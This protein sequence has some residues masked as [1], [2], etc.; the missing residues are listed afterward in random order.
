MPK[1]KD[2]QNAIIEYLTYNRYF[3]YR[4]NTGAAKMANGRFV[5]FGVKGAP[6]IVC[7]I[8]GKFV[9]IEVKRTGGKQSVEQ[10]LFQQALERSGGIY[11]LAYSVDDVINAI[12][13][14]T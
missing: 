8:K 1:E 2:I 11:I 3:F 4:N 9:G 14:H 7:C 5:S 10:K 12:R 13:C 6:D